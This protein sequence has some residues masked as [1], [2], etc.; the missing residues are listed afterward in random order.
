[1]WD[2]TFEG[3]PSETFLVQPRDYHLFRGA[4]GFDSEF[5]PPVCE[6]PT[7]DNLANLDGDGKQAMQLWSDSYQ[8]VYRYLPDSPIRYVEPNPYLDLKEAASIIESLDHLRKLSKHWWTRLGLAS[9]AELRQISEEMG[10]LYERI[11]RHK[12]ASRRH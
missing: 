1:M 7:V 12:R 6:G 2:E 8:R 3:G 11:E 5:S 4:Y 9:R 10:L